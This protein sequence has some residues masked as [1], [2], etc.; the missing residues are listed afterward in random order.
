MKK[1]QRQNLDPSF[2]MFFLF[3]AFPDQAQPESNQLL[4]YRQHG[5]SQ[6]ARIHPSTSKVDDQLIQVAN[7]ISLWRSFLMDFAIFKS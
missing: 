1:Y 5:A 7:E 6:E 2:K 4:H 3:Q